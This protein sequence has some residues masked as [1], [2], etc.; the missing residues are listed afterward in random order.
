MPNENDNEPIG[1]A[2]PIDVPKWSNVME[3]AAL[4]V[5]VSSGSVLGL[6]LMSTPTHAKGATR[7]S[8]LVCQ[9]RETA[10]QQ[11]IALQDAEMQSTAP[12]GQPASDAGK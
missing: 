1:D 12:D 8:K 6:A 11:T 7:S 10:I 5:A 9:Q 3:K 2:A 4:I